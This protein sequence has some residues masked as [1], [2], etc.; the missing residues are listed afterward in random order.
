MCNDSLLCV[1]HHE[2]MNEMP[3]RDAWNWFRFSDVPT[4]VKKMKRTQFTWNHNN[5]FSIHIIK[6]LIYIRSQS[7]LL[8]PANVLVKKTHFHLNFNQP[9][10]CAFFVSVFSISTHC[11]HCWEHSLR[12]QL[13]TSFCICIVNSLQCGMRFLFST[14]LFHLLL[15]LSN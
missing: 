4:G 14:T 7:S 6:K 5:G 8:C 9:C 12:K 3:K 13:A 1:E 2:W 15:K 11:E 10:S